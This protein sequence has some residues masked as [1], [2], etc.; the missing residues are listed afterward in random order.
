V[1]NALRSGDLS[2]AELLIEGMDKRLAPAI[3]AAASLEVNV[4]GL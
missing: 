3:V 2:H 1:E 4:A